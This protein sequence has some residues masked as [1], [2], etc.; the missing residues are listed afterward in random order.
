MGSTKCC[1]SPGR[2]LILVGGTGRVETIW[3]WRSPCGVGRSADP[4]GRSAD[5]DLGP[6]R[7]DGTQSH[8]RRRGPAAE[9]AG[10]ADRCAGH[11]RRGRRRQLRCAAGPAG[12]ESRPRHVERAACHRLGTVRGAGRRGMA[13]STLRS[14]SRPG[15]AAPRRHPVRTLVA[16]S[17][18][19]G[20]DGRA[21]RRRGGFPRGDRVWRWRG[22]GTRGRVGGARR[23][24]HL[25]RR[26]R[27]RRGGPSRRPR[28]RRADHRR[29]R[30]RC[31]RLL[32]GGQRTAVRHPGQGSVAGLRAATRRAPDSGQVLGPQ[33]ADR[34]ACPWALLWSRR[35]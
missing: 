13:G 35:P 27:H 18:A 15:G 29:R 33:S 19:F 22:D 25:R 26:V 4:D 24:R 20:R 10:R 23:D 11:P 16:R 5:G 12:G 9:R 32:S 17:W 14:R 28:G 7:S 3:A 30:E 21:R 1:G 34:R 2:S 8:R 31:R 6:G